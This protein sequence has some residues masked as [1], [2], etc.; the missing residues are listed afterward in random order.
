MKPIVHDGISDSNRLGTPQMLLVNEDCYRIEDGFLCQD[1]RVRDENKD[2][3][4]RPINTPELPWVFAK[5]SDES[6]ALEFAKTY[7]LPGFKE[8]VSPKAWSPQEY[9]FYL[10]LG[11]TQDPIDWVLA[12]AHNVRLILEIS[13]RINQ[14]NELANYL[15]RLLVGDT[16]SRANATPHILYTSIERSGRH[17]MHHSILVDPCSD[18][19]IRWAALL[20]IKNI[21]NTNLHGISN[22]V[23]INQTTENINEPHQ[24]TRRLEGHCLLDFIYWLASESV[25]NDSVRFCD[26]CGNPFVATHRKARYCPPRRNQGQVSPCMNR[27]KQARYKRKQKASEC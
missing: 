19:A 22:V 6:K 4:F 8:T 27:A 1:L 18:L 9:P 24:F 2:S 11:H 25:L 7:G 10:G 17:P 26:H 14:P 23:E 20:M 13:A 5:V 15:K 3:I 21:L 12:H 16:G